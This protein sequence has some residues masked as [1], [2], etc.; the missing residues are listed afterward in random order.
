MSIA[1]ML[2]KVLEHVQEACN[3][4]WLIANLRRYLLGWCR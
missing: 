3:A 1:L 4:V 2:C